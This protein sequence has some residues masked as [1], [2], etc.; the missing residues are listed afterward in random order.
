MG[1]L[2]WIEVD[3]SFILGNFYE[4]DEPREFMNSKNGLI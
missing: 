1:F 3:F 4:K 2:E